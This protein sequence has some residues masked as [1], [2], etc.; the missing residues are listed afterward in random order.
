MHVP[1]IVALVA[2][3]V[4]DFWAKRRRGH[5]DCASP[6]G[7]GQVREDDNVAMLELT[8][9]ARRDFD[10]SGVASLRSRTAFHRR[11]SLPINCGA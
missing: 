9:Y 10:T 3:A 2:P 8:F 5:K 7:S 6:T 4:I 11:T 1:L